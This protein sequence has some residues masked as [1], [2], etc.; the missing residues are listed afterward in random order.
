M[1]DKTTGRRDFDKD[2]FMYE[3]ADEIKAGID[4]DKKKVKGWD[5]TTTGTTRTFGSSKDY[6]KPGLSSTE[7]EKSE[8]VEE[9][10][11]DKKFTTGSSTK[12]PS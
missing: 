9:K 8:S 11:K 12:K 10:N 4:E 3:V 1:A 6:E 2:R 5:E 7:Y